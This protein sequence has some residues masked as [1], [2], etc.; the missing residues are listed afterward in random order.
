MIDDNN[1]GPRPVEVVGIVENVRHTS[2]DGAA[3]L[4]VYIPLS[5]SH[6][7]GATFVRTNQFWM[8]R[9]DF[10]PAGLNTSFVKALQ[11]VD[12][13]AAVSGLGT[14]R[15]G[16]EAW[17]APRRFSLSVFVAFALTAALLA[18]SGVYGLV[19]YAVGQRRRELALRMALGAAAA[20]VRGLVLRQV[21]G[22]GLAGIVFGLLVAILGRPLTRWLVGDTAIDVA[23]SAAIASGIFLMVLLAGV[24]PVRRAGR[25]SPA[26][27]L[28]D[29]P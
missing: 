25:I 27:A 17:F 26:V 29:G 13:D 15:Q 6:P 23:L 19:S 1:T 24:L 9:S 3:G 12:R 18:V 4:D 7:D 14:M 2:M 10:G 21:A 8:I 11:T 22:L 20:D 16:L 5:Q 28:K